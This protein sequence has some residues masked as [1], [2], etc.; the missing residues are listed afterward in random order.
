MLSAIAFALV[1]LWL[2]GMVGGA[3]GGAVHF[4]LVAALALWAYDLI[5]GRHRA[6]L[7]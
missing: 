4:L 3:V 2:I 7:R 6:H 5:L 1:V